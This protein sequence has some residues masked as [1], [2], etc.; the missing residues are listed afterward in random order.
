MK[1]LLV[2]ILIFNSLIFIAQDPIYNKDSTVKFNLAGSPSIGIS[3]LLHD[4]NSL[5][6][7]LSIN[8]APE[9][10]D[11]GFALSVQQTLFSSENLENDTY[12]KFF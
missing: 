8:Q 10:N 6:Q 11:I 5:N 12:M 1:K 3:F 7:E 2:S 4:F 9:L